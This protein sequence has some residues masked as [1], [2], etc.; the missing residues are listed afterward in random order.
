M[1]EIADWLVGE[2]KSDFKLK[3]LISVNLK[4]LPVFASLI[5][6]V[7]ILRSMTTRADMQEVLGDF[8]ELVGVGVGSFL[9]TSQVTLK[10]LNDVV[11][12][13]GM[14]FLTSNKLDSLFEK[15]RNSVDPSVPV[16]FLKD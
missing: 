10:I 14:D 6:I 9:Q 11:C 4:N 1:S 16:D 2:L 13:L 12:L 3:N 15:L 7:V 5:K 8:K